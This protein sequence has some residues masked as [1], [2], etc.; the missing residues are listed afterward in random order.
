MI[1]KNIFS[2]LYLLIKKA[3]L[4]KFCK[5]KINISFTPQVIPINRGILSNIYVKLNKG[6]NLNSIRK[7]FDNSNYNFLKILKLNQ[8]PSINDL[9]GTNYCFFNVFKDRIR[10]RIIII[11]V[12]DNLVKGAAGQA[13]QNMNLKYGFSENE[14][15]S[16]NPIFP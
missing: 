12:I 10:D 16:F 2:N 7:L 8:V 15:L 5:K 9:V 6:R 13:I 11:S 4:S 3:C 1:E 14:G